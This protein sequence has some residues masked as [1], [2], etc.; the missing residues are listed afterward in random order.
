MMRSICRFEQKLAVA[1]REV[2]LA[3]AVAVR[4][5]MGRHQPGLAVADLDEAV[6]QLTLPLRAALTSVPVSLMPASNV[7]RMW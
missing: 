3:V 1:L 6:L 4:A 2:V 7:S 5:D